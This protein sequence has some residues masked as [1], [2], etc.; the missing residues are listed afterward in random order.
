[1]RRES[2]LVNAPSRCAPYAI[3]AAPLPPA[4]AEL[5]ANLGIKTDLISW[6]LGPVLFSGGLTYASVLFSEGFWL[7]LFV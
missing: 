2:Q 7:D 4:N 3:Q 6:D 5:Q 1:M